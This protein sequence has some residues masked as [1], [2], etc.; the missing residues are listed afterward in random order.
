MRIYPKL[1]FLI[2]TILFLILAPI[3]IDTY[4]T[5]NTRTFLDIILL[6]QKAGLAW[7]L[8]W[9]YPPLTIFLV[10][11]AWFFYK[12]TDSE[13][14]YQ[15][16]FKLPLF[17][18]AAYIGNLIYSRKSSG[19]QLVLYLF[20]PGIILLALIWGGFDIIN[21]LFLV[22]VLLF[23]KN[24]K[25][26][27][28]FLYLSASIALR[29][30]TLVLLPFFIW[31]WL[32]RKDLRSI[33]K[34]LAISFSIPITSIVFG[35]FV[36]GNFLFESIASQQ[37]VFGPFGAF[38]LAQSFLVIWNYIGFPILTITNISL[39][40]FF[41][42][43]LSQLILFY[44]FQKYNLSA[45]DASILSLLIFFLFYPKVHSPYILVLLPFGFLYAKW[46]LLKHVWLP[47]TIWALIVNGTFNNQGIFYWFSWL[48]N[49]RFTL[50]HLINVSLT[51]LFSLLQ[52][53]MI[54]F[55]IFTFLRNKKLYDILPRVRL[56][57][58][59]SKRE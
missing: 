52:Q 1:V 15:L 42:L 3:S 23:Y 16:V 31:G 10:F 30:Y 6:N 11:P 59:A 28:A 25:Y 54:V 17:L 46:K 57:G 47:G 48:T 13:F 27:W 51:V 45:I 40:L 24:E 53:A 14:V 12:L 55:A 38:P 58:F 22:L 18:S 8:D 34:Y 43:F 49:F 20:N 5:L 2:F 19:R 56:G 32:A 29:M 37:S 50:P 35:Y 33:L 36:G 41:G 4:N 26:S 7:S 21:S 9:P 44:F 39:F